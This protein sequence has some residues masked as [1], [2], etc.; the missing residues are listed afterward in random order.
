M[1]TVPLREFQR[2]A[3]KYLKQLPVLLTSNNLPIAVISPPPADPKKL[4]PEKPAIIKEKKT[5]NPDVDIVI[6]H[7]IEA[8]RIPKLDLSDKVNRQYAYTLLRKSKTGSDGVVWLIDL[9]ARDP[10]FKHRITSMRDLWSN[11]VKIVAQ[12]R[13]E[14]VKYVDASKL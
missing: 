4:A 6:N 13:K 3:M 12:A 11:Q 14:S 8:M 10:W 1:V 2:S 9:A 5:R 7:L